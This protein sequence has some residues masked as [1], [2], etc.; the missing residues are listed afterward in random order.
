[1]SKRFYFKGRLLPCP[2]RNWNQNARTSPVL[3]P[4]LWGKGL[5]LS[6][7]EIEA[8]IPR[9]VRIGLCSDNNLQYFLQFTHKDKVTCHS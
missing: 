8:N 4:L 5:L 7:S 1:M 6:H 2:H 9:T 3:C